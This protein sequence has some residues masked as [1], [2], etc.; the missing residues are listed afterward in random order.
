MIFHIGKLGVRWYGLVYALGFALIYYVL[1][2]A[3]VQGRIKNLT[4][5]LVDS[6]ILWAIFVT[7]IG[8]RLFHVFIFDFSLYKDNLLDVF[9]IWQ[10]GLAFHGAL[11][12]LVLTTWYFCR[13]HK[14]SF[15]ELADQIVI[16]LSLVLVFGRIANFINAEMVGTISSLPWCVNFPTA[17]GCRHPTQ[18]Y[19]SFKNIFIFGVLFVWNKKS[20]VVEDLKERKGIYFWA[21]IALYGLLRFLLM[22]LRDGEAKVL[23]GLT[24]AQVFALVM[25][26]VGVV[27]LVRFYW[28]R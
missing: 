24:L 10:G 23:L 18:L 13:K 8:A 26:V 6:Y 14:V 5:E 17:E 1:R 27:V 20:L 15:Y 12:G 25:F 4:K 3:A 2:K 9:K 22:F 7:V 11:A 16:P 28:K 19:E 21:F